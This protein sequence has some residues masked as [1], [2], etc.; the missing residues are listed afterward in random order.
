MRSRVERSESAVV[1][2]H[3]RKRPRQREREIEG[4][5][6]NDAITNHRQEQIV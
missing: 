5:R 4:D 2:G 3:S 6:V 1:P